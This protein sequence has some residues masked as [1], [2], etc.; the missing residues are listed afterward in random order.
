VVVSL[1]LL[2]YW[3]RCIKKHYISILLFFVRTKK[4]GYKITAPIGILGGHFMVA[5]KPISSD[6]KKRFLPLKITL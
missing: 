6:P 4:R 3:G 5:R 1:P 2:L